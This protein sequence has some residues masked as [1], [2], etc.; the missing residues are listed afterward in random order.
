L[1]SRTAEYQEKLKEQFL[2]HALPRIVSGEFK[3][4]V[5]RVISWQDIRKG[6]EAMERNEIM[7]KII[8]IVD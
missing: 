7:G 4:N 6:H 5:D 2:E 3:V 8:C 1:R